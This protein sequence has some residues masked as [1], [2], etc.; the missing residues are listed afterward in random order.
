ML[1]EFIN[2]LFNNNKEEKVLKEGT[3]KFFNVKKGFGF[4]KEKD[5]DQDIFVHST[6]LIDKIR[7]NDRVQFYVKQDEKGPSAVKVKLI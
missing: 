5:S 3:V 6:N 4:I 1:K 7:E 2:R